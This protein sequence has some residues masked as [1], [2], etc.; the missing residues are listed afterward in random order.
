MN[1]AIQNAFLAYKKTG[2][3][4]EPVLRKLVKDHV[5]DWVR[6]QTGIIVM[7]HEDFHPRAAKALEKLSGKKIF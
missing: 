5:Q 7:A 1:G 6:Q 3:V 2:K 4:S